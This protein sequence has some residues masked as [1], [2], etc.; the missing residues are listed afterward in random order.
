MKRSSANLKTLARE[1]L[2]GN[3]GVPIAAYLIIGI[4]N[5]ALTM[6]T[7]WLLDTSSTVSMVTSQILLYIVSLLSSLLMVGFDKLMLNL[8]RR[9]PYTVKDIFYVFS[10][11]PDRFLIVNFIILLAGV[12]VS[13]PFDIPGFT[14]SS[15]TAL[16]LSFAGIIVRSLVSILLAS[17]F[18]LANYLLLDNPEMGAMESMRESLTLMK[19]NKG[20]FLYVYFSFLPL[21]IVSIFTCYIGLLWLTPYIQ[22]TMAYFYMDIIGEL[23]K[24]EPVEGEFTEETIVNNFEQ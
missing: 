22:G 9:K 21:T 1:S 5:L 16:M 7:T 23:D 2:S 14:S 10:N 3:F 15:N 17:F 4:L 24:T 8:N 18:G 13:L 12:L 11:S 19:G 20:R 6:I